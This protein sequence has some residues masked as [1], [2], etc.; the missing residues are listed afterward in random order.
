[1]SNGT[2]TTITLS[3]SIDQTNLVLE[4]LGALPFARVFELIG[5]IQGQAK[6]QLEEA[7]AVAPAPPPTVVGAASGE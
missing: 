2:K 6:R 5:S 7:P 1:M 3:L 4:A